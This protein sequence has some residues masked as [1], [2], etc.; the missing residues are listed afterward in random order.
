MN[1]LS[2]LEEC[3]K[4]GLLRRVPGSKT[5]AERSI[6][7]AKA[8]LAEAKEGLSN[9]MLDA[10]IMLSYSSV[11]HASRAILIRDGLR[12][13]SHYCIDRYLEEE[14]AD[15]K[16]L[17]HRVIQLLDRARELRHEDL[18]TLDFYPMEEEAESAVSNADFVLR[19]LKGLLA[20]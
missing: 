2:E 20:R 19:K 11:F 4:K 6:K 5:G 3:F 14:Y 15:K 7:K 9:K 1:C 8:M 13:R 10:T 17:E 18:Y 16:K 12:E